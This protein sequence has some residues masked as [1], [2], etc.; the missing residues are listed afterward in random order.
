MRVIWKDTNAKTCPPMM[1]RKVEI[2]RYEDDNIKGWTI[3][4]EG[5]NNVYA[6]QDC[7]R[8]AI[9]K[10]LGIKPRKDSSRQGLAGIKI[11]GQKG[12]E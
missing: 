12:Q 10:A 6:S 9:I 4:I 11:V 3:A 5:D 7:A 1:Y 2:K 8:N